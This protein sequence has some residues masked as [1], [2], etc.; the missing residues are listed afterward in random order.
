MTSAAI[1]LARAAGYVSAGTVEFLVGPDGSFYFLEMNTRLQV[2]H[3][4]TELI[5]GLDLVEWQ[6][7]IAR[8]EALAIEQHAVEAYGHA[9]EVRLCAEDPASGFLPATG[10]LEQLHVPVADGI[11]V[12]SGFRPGDEISPYYDSLLLKVMAHGATR[13]EALSRLK[14][15]LENSTVLGVA[16]NR[17]FLFRLLKL[18]EATEGEIDTGLIEREQ[19][20]LTEPCPSLP[21]LAWVMAALA[22]VNPHEHGQPEPATLP[23]SPWLWPTTWRLNSQARAILGFSHD[24]ETKDVQVHWEPNALMLEMD[25]RTSRARAWRD[26]TGAVRAELDGREYP[27]RSLLQQDRCHVWIEGKEYTLTY[28]DPL[29]SAQ[30]AEDAEHSLRSPMPGRVIAVLVQPGTATERGMPLMV[31]EAMKM[32]HT[33]TAPGRGIVAAVH[34]AE[35]DQVSGGAALLQFEPAGADDTAGAQARSADGAVPGASRS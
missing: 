6:L 15:T 16:N 4:V 21:R 10:R 9:I 17:E 33:I 7:R 30:R 27:A 26:E 22:V 28:L 5:T 14:R 34:F 20:R 13:P 1:A 12:D 35:G 24:Q 31:I 3:G 18:P 8:G 32:E 25:G 23:R 19:T 2:E 11:R 29:R